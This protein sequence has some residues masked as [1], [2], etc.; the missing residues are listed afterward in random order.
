MFKSFYIFFQ[1]P[2]LLSFCEASVSGTSNSKSLFR[3]K[4][5]QNIPVYMHKGRQRDISYPHHPD[6]SRE[7]LDE[8]YGSK[9]S[10]KQPS[11]VFD[12]RFNEEVNISTFSSKRSHKRPYKEKHSKLPKVSTKNLFISEDFQ[13]TPLR[14]YQQKPISPSTYCLSKNDQIDQNGESLPSHISILDRVFSSADFIETPLKRRKFSSPVL[15]PKTSTPKSFKCDTSLTQT[16]L[17]SDGILN[18]KL[19]SPDIKS[20]DQLIVRNMFSGD[21]K[22]C[23]H[24]GD[25]AMYPE[26]STQK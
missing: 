12:V 24:M 9:F 5:K 7:I 2:K 23:Y 17:D 11:K 26:I 1:T 19:Q 18:N 10:A 21:P 20:P 15:Y 8:H 13:I 22:E 14:N 6:N 25:A 16:S 4:T 3:E